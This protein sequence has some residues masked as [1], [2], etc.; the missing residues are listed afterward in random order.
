MPMKRHFKYLEEITYRQGTTV[1]EV[2][3][4]IGKTV[5]YTENKGFGLIINENRVCVGVVTDGDIRYYMLS[6]NSLDD[7]I[8]KVMNR[9]FIFSWIDDSYHQILRKFDLRIRNLP[10]LD[11]D[12]HPVDLYKYSR[13][14]ASARV[15]PKIIRARVPVRVSFSGGG[16]DMSQFMNHTSTAV[17]SS[18]INKYCTASVIVRNDDKINIISKDLNL[19][20]NADNVSE[21][22][23]GDQMDLIKA[24]V[25]IMQPG[26]GFD[27]ETFA[28]FEPGTG[29]GGSSA[30][31][32]SVIG[33]LNYF[34]NENQLDI[35]HIADLAY[36]VERIDLG[37]EGGWQDQYATSFGGFSWIEFRKNEVL[38]NPLRIQ[39]NTLLE[40]EYNLMLFRLGGV[41]ES[42][43]LQK[44]HIADL[45]N[46][47]G[48]KSSYFSEMVEMATRMKETLLKGD[49]KKFGDLLHDSW[50]QKKK[51]GGWVT[52]SHIEECYEAA[53]RI[54]A[55]GGKLL[56]AGGSGYLLIYASP[57]YQKEIQ[58]VL[59]SKGACLDSIKFNTDGLEVWSTK[60]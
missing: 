28:E 15:E 17:L 46:Q 56:G 38:V 37:I 23:Y 36:Q 13:F 35:Y 3:Q 45:N 22:K 51:L 25:K 49:V 19:R 44:Q 53:R 48:K 55:L 60:K 54:G 5:C 31:A 42:S 41:R 33:A 39:R 14:V 12:G 8:E 24:A 52:N 58:E 6:N 29:L 34:R 20:Y 26:F 1:R 27:L 30:V 9:D 21:I 59:E 40:L 11:R 4:N 16:T 50:G 18:T 2:M 57:L 32:V 10:I 7:S 47:N 43:K